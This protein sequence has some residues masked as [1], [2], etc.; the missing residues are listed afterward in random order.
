VYLFIFL[1]NIILNVAKRRRRRKKKET[2]TMLS[3]IH[4]C[5][6]DS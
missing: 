5:T 3:P 4:R 6:A 2:V 1:C